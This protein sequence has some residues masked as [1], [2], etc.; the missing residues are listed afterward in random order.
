MDSMESTQPGV[1]TGTP[2]PSPSVWSRIGNVFFSPT[3][4]FE[5]YSVS[6]S[7]LV[8]LI[9]LTVVLSIAMTF[10]IMKYQT[11]EQI[12][13]L[14]TSPNIPPQALEQMRQNAENPGLVG[15]IVVTPIVILIIG[16]IGALLAWMFGGFIFGGKKVSFAT[17][18]SVA[19]LGGLISMIGAVLKVPLIIAK[20]SVR[21]SFGLAALLGSMKPTA[22]FYTFA[23]YLDVFAIW[24]LI[25]TGIGYAL[26][27][28]FTRG[29]GIAIS[30]LV[31]VIVLGAAISLQVMGLMLAGVDVTFF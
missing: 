6:T 18:W 25:V 30:V 21:V 31:W 12:R 17:V 1:V 11:L 28:G 5:N 20:E 19:L 7:A 27:F 16:I 3:Q 15:S 14:E 22:I 13:V 26:I 9:I 29:K 24:S 10:P 2:G 8:T 4:A 23:S